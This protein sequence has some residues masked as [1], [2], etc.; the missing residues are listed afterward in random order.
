MVL[1]AVTAIVAVVAA[2]GLLKSYSPWETEMGPGR[3]E[4]QAGMALKGVSTLNL[5]PLGDI[6]AATHDAPLELTSTLSRLD[7][8]QVQELI[9]SP[10]PADDLS[11]R[12]EADLDSALTEFVART[13]AL[14]AVVGL[15]AA[16]VVARRDWWSLIIGP[17]ASVM[18]VG[19]L[20]VV[21]WRTYELQAFES[22]RFTG[23]LAEAPRVLDTLRRHVRSFD[24]AKARVAVMSDQIADFYQ[25]SALTEPLS[26]QDVRLLH[27]SDLH[28][29]PLGFETARR[30]AESFQ[31]H[32][33]VDTGDITSFGSPVESRVLE[34]LRDMPAPY[35]VVPGNHD[36][37]AI[38]ETL[39]TV[40]GVQVLDGQV[41]N[42]NGLELLGVADPTFTADNLTPQ[43]EADQAQ[44][45]AAFG[46]AD[47]L[48]ANGD[49]DVLA[50]HSPLMAQRAYGEVPLILAGH[51]HRKAV[52]LRNDT[53]G[54]VVG[55]T[56]AGGVG[57]FTTSDETE[58]EAQVL[59]F[60]GGILTAVDYVRF[61]SLHEDF[62]VNR[63][64][65]PLPVTGR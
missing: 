27:V 53:Y 45:I 52:T 32:A 16:L 24:D 20:L 56:G 35:Y 5:P 2:L 54:L 12:I 22:P 59:Y 21:S 47:R 1:R 65:M 7:G 4:L 25:S 63:T 30:L 14:A 42:I 39:A 8:R 50:V 19:G 6:S 38:R 57:I 29:N 44:R 43:A 61:S 33:V 28:S 60:R 49:V 13:L 37:A 34:L 18:A 48:Q 10:D 55:S 36:S 15:V 41:V 64:A 9:A 46:V 11:K 31:V 40:P 26:E 62:S 51:T 58:Y 3:L 17:M 23:S